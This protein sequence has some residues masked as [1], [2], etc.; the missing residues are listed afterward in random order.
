MN[1]LGS[2]ALDL[3]GSAAKPNAPVR[4]ANGAGSD[5]AC[6]IRRR[7][8]RPWENWAKTARCRPEWSFYPHSLQELVHIVHFARGSGK[9]IR[10][11]GSGHSWSALVPTEEVLVFVDQLKEVAMD[12]SDPAHPRIS[13]ESGATVLKVNAVLELYGYALPSNVV[14]ESV[15]FGGLIATGSHGS[16]WNNL[17][18][19]DLVHSIEIVTASGELRKFE[20]GVDSDEVMN[21]ARLNLGLFGITY[22]VTLNVQ[23]NWTVRA[24]D[25]RL[26]IPQ[27]LEHLREYVLSHENLDLFW[28][29]FCDR[30][31]VKS[32]EPVEGSISAQPRRGLR[33]KVGAAISSQ[34]LRGSLK[35]LESFPQLT[36]KV[37]QMDFTATP[38]VRD[39]VVHVVEA[40][41]YRRGLELAK[42]GCVEIA[43]KID[44]DFEN[45]KWAIRV[46]FER[47]RA[48]A[49]RGQYP[50]NVTMSARFIHKSDC[51]LSPAFGEGHT[52][53]IE[54]VSRTDPCLW[55][56]F[57]GEV[58]R[59]WLTLRQARPHWAKEYRHIPGIIE[60]L[61]S[62]FA[63]NLHRFAQIKERLRLDPEHMF[64]NSALRELF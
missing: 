53:Y 32:W 47:V 34:L 22:R 1:I 14:L 55:K 57:S 56:Q 33:D 42:L 21:A 27:V 52:C 18:L 30:F 9:R 20:A 60:H 43:F 49:A 25:R 50:L 8:N 5:A 51:W 15:R 28:W 4:E 26:P 7:Q 11:A 38:S 10:V 19:S 31:W 58:A 62:H 59:D 64:V 13:I 16:G 29:P 3:K 63:E 6:Q 2:G 12:F 35:L 46:A 17:T 24:R 54:I 39:D 44:P 45:V 41:H 40:I 36:P 37:C 48:Y 23:S 61:K